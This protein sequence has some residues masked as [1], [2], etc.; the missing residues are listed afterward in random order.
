MCCTSQTSLNKKQTKKRIIAITFLVCFI[1]ISLLSEAFILTH[2]NH[3]H[4]QNG[5][6]GT[7]ATCVQI[8]NAENILKQLGTAVVGGFIILAGLYAAAAIIKAICSNIAIHTPITLKIRM[9]N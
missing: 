9:N 7:C 8:Q 5:V 2:A 4:D 6:G 3:T 1:A